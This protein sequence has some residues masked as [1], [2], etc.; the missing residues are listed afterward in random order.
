MNGGVHIVSSRGARAGMFIISALRVLKRIVA[1]EV[2]E[3]VEIKGLKRKNFSS[4]LLIFAATMC[5]FVGTILMFT[6]KNVYGNL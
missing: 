4:I 1:R 2:S 3:V 5:I 6:A